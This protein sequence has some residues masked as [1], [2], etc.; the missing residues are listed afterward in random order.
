MYFKAPIALIVILLIPT[1]IIPNASNEQNDPQNWKSQKNFFHYSI[2]VIESFANKQSIG[3][4]VDLI[5]KYLGNVSQNETSF[6]FQTY[7]TLVNYAGIE[8]ANGIENIQTR[9]MNLNLSRST[10]LEGIFSYLAFNSTDLYN[11]FV[12]PIKTIQNQQNVLIW[13]YNHTFN[14]TAQYLWF[15]NSRNVS[16]Y[17][18]QNS[19]VFDVGYF[20]NVFGILLFARFTIIRSST[21]FNASVRLLSTSLYLLQ[22]SV[23][24]INY[25]IAVIICLAIPLTII[26]IYYF[27]KHKTKK[28]QSGGLK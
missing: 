9:L 6:E 10:V 1:F 4:Q 2:N 17:Q 28:I 16:V 25:L 27:K 3:F 15:G 19:E 22:G 8:T 11:P 7:S 24:L 18:S 23:P 20:D 26:F 12:I 21:T 5:F 13:N 14:E